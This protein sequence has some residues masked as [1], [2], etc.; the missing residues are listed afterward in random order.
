MEIHY[1]ILG[2]LSIIAL[3]F[4]GVVIFG[5]LKIRKQQK[6]ITYLNER[7]EYSDRDIQSRFQD[8]YRIKENDDKLK[9]YILRNCWDQEKNIT[10]DLDKRFEG[11]EKSLK[12]YTDSR[13][14]KLIDTYFEVKELNKKQIIKG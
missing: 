4:V 9:P 7:I 14:D 8:L 10:H 3:A 1:F 13:I 11:I 12:G 5:L 2:M 6:T